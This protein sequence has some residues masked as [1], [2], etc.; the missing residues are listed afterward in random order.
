MYIIIIIHNYLLFTKLQTKKLNKGHVPTNSRL[1][2]KEF[3]YIALGNDYAVI[4]NN[5]R[6]Y[7]TDRN[8]FI[9]AHVLYVQA[10]Y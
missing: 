6:I 1:T 2:L 9:H 7:Y 3:Y 5:Y 4:I 10:I 8:I